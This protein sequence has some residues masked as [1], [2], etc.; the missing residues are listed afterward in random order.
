M[1]ENRSTYAGRWTPGAEH[2][3]YG[4]GYR[5]QDAGYMT[6]RAWFGRPIGISIDKTGH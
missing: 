5:A 1:A 4:V 6:Q 2:R 3:V